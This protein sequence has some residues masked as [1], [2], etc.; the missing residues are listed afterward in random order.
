MKTEQ[1]LIDDV[2]DCANRVAGTSLCMLPDEDIT[3]EAFHFDSLGLFAF[4]LE[5]EHT[6]GI[7]F[8]DA[9]INHERLRSI[10]SVAALVASRFDRGQQGSSTLQGADGVHHV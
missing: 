8:D 1:Q 7:E 9:L 3:L 6:C 10:R 2:L 4:I 5:L